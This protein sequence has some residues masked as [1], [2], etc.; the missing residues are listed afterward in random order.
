MQVVDNIV[1]AAMFVLLLAV[2]QLTA[3]GKTQNASQP[4]IIFILADDLVSSSHIL[5]FLVDY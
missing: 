2:F 1:A 3:A 5:A 4:H